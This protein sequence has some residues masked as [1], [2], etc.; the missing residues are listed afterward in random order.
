MKKHIDTI[1][2]AWKRLCEL[3]I[4]IINILGGLTM[5]YIKPMIQTYND[6]ELEE[7]IVGAASCRPGAPCNVNCGCGGASK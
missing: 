7:I 3:T 5:M 2:F 4:N 1:S 6:K